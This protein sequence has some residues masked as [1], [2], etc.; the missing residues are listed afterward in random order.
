MTE[1]EF[2]DRLCASIID[3]QNIPKLQVERLVGPV[4]GIFLQDILDALAL[5]DSLPHGKYEIVS[6]EWPLRIQEPGFQS[7]NIDWLAINRSNLSLL[8]IELKTSSS[9]IDKRQKDIYVEK[10]KKIRRETAG[11]LLQDIEEIAPKSAETKKYR[12]LIS[13]ARNLSFDFSA[14]REVDLL[15]IVPKAG[16][17]SVQADDVKWMI[18][19]EDLPELLPLHSGEAWSKLRPALIELDRGEARQKRTRPRNENEYH[20]RIIKEVL[21]HFPNKNPEKI[22]FGITGEGAMPNFEVHFT[23]GTIQPFHS[24]GTPYRVKRFKPGN[25]TGPIQWTDYLFNPRKK[26]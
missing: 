13:K 11:F 18:S 24:S 15:Y 19:F 25:L 7:T 6:P 26:P 12:H 17:Q 21:R 5:K 8:F 3:H 16:K 4:L 9:S 20:V 10:M 1:S 2:V 14:C 23:D 22:F